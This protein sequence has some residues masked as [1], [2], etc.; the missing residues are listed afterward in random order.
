MNQITVLF[1]RKDSHYKTLPNVDVW[2]IDRDALNWPG[3]TPCIAHPPCRAW[4]QLRHM[5][6]PRKGEKALALWALD[7]V[8]EHSGV[9]E[10]PKNSTLWR[11]AGLLPPGT[12]DLYGGWLFPILQ[13]QFAH[14]AD[15]PTY[16]YI[17]G[18]PPVAIPDYPLPLAYATHIIGTPG[19]RKNGSRLQPGDHGYRPEVT[20]V[21]REH[22]PPA[23]CR[24][25]VELAQTC[26]PGN[27]TPR[28]YTQIIEPRLHTGAQ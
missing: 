23:L 8:R 14:K 28:P 3:G 7:Q 17:V 6:K 21:D 24:W 10:H 4:G 26:R 2:D 20:K 13:S 19:R 25:L 22:T 5:A 11:S 16:L 27:P 18:C 15:K 12:R 9:L 1:A